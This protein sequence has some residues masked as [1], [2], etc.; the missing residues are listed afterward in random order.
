MSVAHKLDSHYGGW[1]PSL[2]DQRDAIADA[3]GIAVKPEV[4]PRPKM[5]PIFDQ[6]QLG[7]C[8]ANTIAAALEFDALLDGIK[9]GRLS[10][11]WVYWQ[12]RRLEHS[13]GQGDTGAFGRDG[14]KAA[15]QVGV[16]AE[17]D[18]PYD[19]AT[20]DPK[21][22][23]AKATADEHHYRL[24]KPYAA[25]PQRD[26]S[27]RAVLSNA[28]T[29]AFGFTVYESFESDAVART[30][31]VPMPEPGERQLG[32][33]ETLAIGYL[34]RYPGYYL[35]RNSWGPGWGLKGYFLMPVPYLLDPS[36]SGDLRTIQ[37]SIG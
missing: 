25:V 13:L 1:R 6:G 17:T 5:P 24:T 19:I 29:I 32:G 23:P 27:I 30:G 4:D 8:T 21:T 15:K 7:S 18:W 34:R 35:V 2:P 33:H 37:R 22:P 28:Q 12:E 16:C 20:F 31:V 11:L 36:L 9:T 10:R 3:S 14:F 26:A